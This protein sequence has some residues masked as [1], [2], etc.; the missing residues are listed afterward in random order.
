[1]I[2]VVC[3]KKRSG[4]TEAGNFLMETGLFNSYALGD[5]VKETLEEA[6]KNK[7]DVGEPAGKL[8]SAKTLREGDRD[9]K[10]LLMSNKDVRCLMDA[11]IAILQEKG[12]IPRV[13]EVRQA[14]ALANTKIDL[15]MHNDMPWTPRRLM[16]TFATD[17][18]CLAIDDSVFVR[19]TLE[20]MLKNQS[21]EHVL[22]TDCRQP[23][24]YKYLRMLGAKFIFIE[25][26]TGFV[27]NHY[28]EQ[29]I[30]PMFGE[31]IINNNGTLS[32]LK[33]AVLNA[34]NE[35]KQ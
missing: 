32:E 23:H 27:D 6:G 34:I 9:G 18:V 3:G 12:F 22:I 24:E 14:H 20:R 8:E 30:S 29:G 5:H 33:S 13:L 4:K 21:A 28:S 19:M 15:I 17:L 31:T 2:V 35:I 7:F 11:S 10:V 16:Q 1:M 25:R 26:D